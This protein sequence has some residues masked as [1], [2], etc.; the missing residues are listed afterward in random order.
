MTGS[1]ES[2]TSVFRPGLPAGQI[3]RSL[4]R[5]LGARH[6]RV[7]CIRRSGPFTPG[8]RLLLS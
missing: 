7:P 1:A 3:A 6:I 4:A 2:P 5:D 8:S